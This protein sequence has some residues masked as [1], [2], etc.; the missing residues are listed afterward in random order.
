MVERLLEMDVLH[1]MKPR[2]ANTFG[3]TNTMKRKRALVS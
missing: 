3:F 2:A 1:M